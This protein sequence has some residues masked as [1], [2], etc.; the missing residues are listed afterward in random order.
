M[1][2]VVSLPKLA[3]DYWPLKSKRVLPGEKNSLD[4]QVRQL[5]VSGEGF[6]PNQRVQFVSRSDRK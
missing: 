3:N 1:K 4:L 5:T 2:P 6:T